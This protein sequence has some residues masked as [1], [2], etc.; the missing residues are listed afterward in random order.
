MDWSMLVGPV[1]GFLSMHI[2]GGSKKVFKFIDR[3]PPPAQQAAVLGIAI[4]TVWASQW[5]PGLSDLVAASDPNAAAG[6]AAA[7]A[8]GLHRSR[9]TN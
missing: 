4:G 9:S 1:F 7:T 3:F 8:Y 6:I 5:V 2:F